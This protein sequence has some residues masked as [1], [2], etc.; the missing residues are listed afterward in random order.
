MLGDLFS[1]A[2]RTP[3]DG[4]EEWIEH[5]YDWR[6]E[7]AAAF[8]GADLSLIDLGLG[9]FT[10]DHTVSRVTLACA[11]STP[12]LFVRD[13]S[14]ARGF[15]NVD[16]VV[17]RTLGERAFRA[18]RGRFLGHASGGQLDINLFAQRREL[19]RG[20]SSEGKRF[21][22][23]ERFVAGE[24]GCFFYH[25]PI[26]DDSTDIPARLEYGVLRGDGDWWIDS[27]QNKVDP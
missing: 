19:N 17:R 27:F 2:A 6:D 20:W 10:F 23:M 8:P 18:D 14:R 11:I 16:E 15:P 3:P 22:A 7:Y 12:Q 5:A 24:P 25:R 1:R 9:V 26:Y 13:R 4:V 21:R